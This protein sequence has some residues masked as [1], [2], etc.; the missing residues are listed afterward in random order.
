MCGIDY[1][2]NL[3]KNHINNINDLINVD[4]PHY[5]DKYFYYPED[6]K[7]YAKY[8]NI[9]EDVY[10]CITKLET[11]NNV[12][13]FCVDDADCYDIDFINFKQELNNN[14]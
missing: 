4:Y 9:Y 10:L 8:L 14:N 3:S 7:I 2:E 6:I 11:N 5:K 12:S 1:I 13:L